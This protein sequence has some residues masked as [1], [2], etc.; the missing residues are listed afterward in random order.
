MYLIIHFSYY[1][2]LISLKGLVSS[3][4]L[5]PKWFYKIISFRRE[6]DTENLNSNIEI[7]IVD[8]YF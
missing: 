8:F 3:K 4:I 5:S 6:F 1:K 2:I 7:K